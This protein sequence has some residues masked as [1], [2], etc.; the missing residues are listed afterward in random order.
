[1][2]ARKT[3]PR[4]PVPSRFAWEADD[5]EFSQCSLCVH[6]RKN[7]TCAAFPKGIPIGITKNEIDHRRPQA[8][9]HGIQWKGKAGR[10]HPLAAR[11]RKRRE[12]N[13]RG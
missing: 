13:R 2:A 10:E 5:I 6:D 12:A 11:E 9:D 4:D 1:M 7:G 8:G 3:K